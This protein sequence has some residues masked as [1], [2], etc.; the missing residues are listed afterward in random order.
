MS[1][2][3][4]MSSPV[5]SEHFVEGQPVV[6]EM[7]GFDWVGGL[8][9]PDSESWIF[10]RSDEHFA[11]ADEDRKTKW[12]QEKRER[13]KTSREDWKQ[14][15]AALPEWLRA[16]LQRFHEAGGETFALDGW[17]Y[18]LVICELA[19]AL[20]WTDLVALIVEDAGTDEL[21]PLRPF[22]DMAQEEVDAWSIWHVAR[23]IERRGISPVLPIR[24]RSIADDLDPEGSYLRQEGSDRAEEA[25]R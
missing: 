13:L 25:L 9:L 8:R 22:G 11:A 2:G 17:G 20:D 4:T 24:L 3:W 1:D 6:R 19:E 21:L 23:V 16:R 7:F 12:D 10:H 18:E 5:D 14:R 15:E